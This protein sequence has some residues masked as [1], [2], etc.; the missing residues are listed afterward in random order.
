MAV[1]KLPTQQLPELVK[2]QFL[3]YSEDRSTLSQKVLIKV[4]KI[5][6]MYQVDMLL[7]LLVMKKKQLI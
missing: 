1:E 6:S 3:M 5:L 7:V 2:E 4:L